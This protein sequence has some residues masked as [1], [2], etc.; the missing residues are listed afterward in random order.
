[1][2]SVG[3]FEGKKNLKGVELPK[4]KEKSWLARAIFTWRLPCAERG[5]LVPSEKEGFRR[6]SGV[7]QRAYC[8]ASYEVDGGK[9]EM[10]KLARI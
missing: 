5:Q 3:D 9:S 2:R 4:Q 7:E 6:S 1:V 10:T 8:K